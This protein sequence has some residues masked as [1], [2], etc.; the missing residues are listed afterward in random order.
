[1]AY[2]T[3]QEKVLTYFRGVDEQNI[4]MILNTLSKECVFSVETHNVKLIGH[5]AIFDMFER[6]WAHHQ[7]VRHDNFYFVTNRSESDVAVRFQ[8]TNKLHDGNLVY[9]SNCNFFTV[10]GDLFSEVRVYMS[11]E[12][13][14]ETKS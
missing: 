11:G 2:Q 8:V 7:W 14:L 12:N 1:M 6:L 10:N 3:L 4:E 9:K 5:L 13:T